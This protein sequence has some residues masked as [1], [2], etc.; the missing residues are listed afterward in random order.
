VTIATTI[1]PAAFGL[2]TGLA[3]IVAIGAQNAYLLRLAVIAGTRTVASAVAVCALSDGVL[4]LAGVL[5]VGAIVDRFPIALVV[6]RFVG[7][8]FL[9]TYGGFAALRAIRPAEAAI[10]VRGTAGDSVPPT[11]RR[12]TLTMLAFTWLNPH[13]YLDTL[14]FLGSVANEQGAAE[15]WWWV[16]GAFAASCLWFAA[17]G[18]GARLLRPVFARPGA[19][20][21]FDACIALVMFTFGAKLPLGA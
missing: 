7:A 17:L 8:A 2:G 19:W 13:V 14:V 18:F 1:L 21:V 4:I 5:G 20:R 12:A 11:L 10:D 16:A 3:L 9:L 6:V 15:R